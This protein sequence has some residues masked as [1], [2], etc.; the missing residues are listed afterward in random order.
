[1]T[2]KQDSKDNALI[3][4][5]KGAAGQTGSKFGEDSKTTKPGVKASHDD[6]SG[7]S[8]DDWDLDSP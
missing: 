8:D 2:S 4:S 1:M 3:S 7:Y 6:D 5:F